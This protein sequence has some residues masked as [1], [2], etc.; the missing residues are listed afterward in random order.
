MCIR[1][2]Q[3]RQLPAVHVEL[4]FGPLEA[5]LDSG[6]VRSLMSGHMYRTLMPTSSS[7]QASP[8]QATC[9]TAVSHSFPVHTVVKSEVRV[10]K[11]T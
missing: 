3:S 7:A 2:V 6:A 4:G 8:V 11:Y 10:D 5:L 1:G 9:I